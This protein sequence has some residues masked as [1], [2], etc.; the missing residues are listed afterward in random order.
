MSSHLK[1]GLMDPKPSFNDDTKCEECCINKP[2]PWLKELL[3]IFGA[4]PALPLIGIKLS[5][6]I[7]MLGCD[8]G[9]KL[10]D[11]ILTG[12]VLC[13]KPGEKNKC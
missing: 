9:L 11:G 13:S 7:N 12:F 1:S 4:E 5:P 10:F 3:F 6:C 2:S 8:E